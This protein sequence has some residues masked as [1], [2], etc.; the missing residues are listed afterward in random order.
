MKMLF[1]KIKETIDSLSI[2]KVLSHL[3]LLAF[4]LFCI[5]SL[6]IIWQVFIGNSEKIIGLI[7]ALTIL[8][9]ALLASYS[10]MLSIENTNKNEKLKIESRKRTNVLFL[11]QVSNDILSVLTVYKDTDIGDFKINTHNTLL[12]ILEKKL[13]SL[14]NKEIIENLS[15]DEINLLTLVRLRIY[16][17]VG[18]LYNYTQGIVV[19]D[20]KKFN[21]DIKFIIDKLNLLIPLL[22]KNN[23]I[24]TQKMEQK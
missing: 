22:A 16:E 9:S 4:S 21:S 5:L 13:Y 23:N 17:S 8:I 24:S 14:E 1:F 3:K 7:A 18:I 19:D 12:L 15:D 2:I 20:P 10:V 6:I 11:I